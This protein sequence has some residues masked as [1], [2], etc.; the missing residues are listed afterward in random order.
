MKMRWLEPSESFLAPECSLAGTDAQVAIL[1]APLEIS[2][3]YGRGSAAG[4]NAIL[5]ASRQVEFFDTELGF[6][7][8]RKVQIATASPVEPDGLGA[9]AYAE[10][11]QEAVGALLQEGQ[12]VIVLGGEHSSAVGAVRAHCARF[13]DVTVLQ[14]DAHSDLRPVYLRDPWNHA[15]TMARVRDFQERIVQVGIRSEGREERDLVERERIGL[16]RPPHPCGRRERP[17]LDRFDRR[18]P[19]PASLCYFR[20]RC[21]GSFG[22]PGYGSPRAWGTHMAPGEWVA[23]ARVRG[24]RGCWPGCVR[25]G[26]CHRLASSAG[27][28][29]EADLPLHRVAFR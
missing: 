19:Q 14:I 16:L 28:L 29:G 12:F 25:V 27:C 17:G 8:C 9:A 23:V 3:T 26:A 18:C 2:S 11:L 1:Q 13:P 10:R 5:E 15:C 6:A 22:Y 21:L 24:T 4:P 7:P 20:L